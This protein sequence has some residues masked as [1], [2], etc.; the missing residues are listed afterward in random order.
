VHADGAVRYE[1]AR[2]WAHTLERFRLGEAIM[3]PTG[4]MASDLTVA[5]QSEWFG[6]AIHRAV[7]NAI[8][9]L[10][11]RGARDLDVGMVIAELQH[12]GTYAEF[13]NASSYVC[14]LTDGAV[15]PPSRYSRLFR[16][17]EMRRAWRE[18]DL[19]KAD[20]HG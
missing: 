7:F 3:D 6:D 11:R 2:N 13:P 17:E 12:Q 8:R 18:L 1:R 19:A 4:Y 20:A 16:L 9:A 14:S 5:F 15:P 10:I